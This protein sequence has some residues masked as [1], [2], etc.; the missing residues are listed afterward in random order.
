LVLLA[1]TTAAS[2]LVWNYGRSI[3]SFFRQG[4]PALT[5][6]FRNLRHFLKLWTL[7]LA[8]TT[9]VKIVTVL[10]RMM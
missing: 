2:V 4:E 5:R 9:V 8:L 3:V 10:R 7:L 6:A 1:A